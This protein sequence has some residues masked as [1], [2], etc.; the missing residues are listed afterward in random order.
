MDKSLYDFRIPK[1]LE[2]R[3]MTVGEVTLS[4][5]QD[6][7]Y[8]IVNPLSCGEE[9]KV[10]R[11]ESTRQEIIYYCGDGTLIGTQDTI[12]MKTEE[13]MNGLERKLNGLD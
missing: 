9:F 12:G 10:T 11:G 13:L 8:L 3:K 1:E 2:G 5:P 6:A 4:F 7:R